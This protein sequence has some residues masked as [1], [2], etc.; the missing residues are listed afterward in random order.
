MESKLLDPKLGE[1]LI[2]SEIKGKLIN[3]TA[4]HLTTKQEK[5]AT[6]TLSENEYHIGVRRMCLKRGGKILN[7]SKV[8]LDG[9]HNLNKF[10]E[11]IEEAKIVEDN[12]NS[13][14]TGE[15]N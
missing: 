5:S 3:I 9:N 10:E 1:L 6:S 13:P 15:Q 7:G 11:C 2:K 14:S 12:N 8:I 4:I